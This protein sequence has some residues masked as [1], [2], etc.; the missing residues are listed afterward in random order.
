MIDMSPILESQFCL[1]E[2]HQFI[3][4]LVLFATTVLLPQY[5]QAYWIHREPSGRG[6]SPGGLTFILMIPLVGRLVLRVERACS[7]GLA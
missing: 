1:F 6:T 2:C 5:Q 7:W 3:I 4:G